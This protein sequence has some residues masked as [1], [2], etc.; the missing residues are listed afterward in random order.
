[1]GS[2][3]LS[4]NSH[5]FPSLSYPIVYIKHDK[6][7]KFQC[8]QA[9]AE[10]YQAHLLLFFIQSA[11]PFVSI[12]SA[13]VPLLTGLAPSTSMSSSTPIRHCLMCR[14]QFDIYC[15]CELLRRYL[16]YHEP[17]SYEYLDYFHV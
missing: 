17:F 10:L 15:T 3:K 4:Q 5:T 8:K 6:L 7:N 9:R 11:L 13:F 2:R 12:L 14:V 16:G 1:M